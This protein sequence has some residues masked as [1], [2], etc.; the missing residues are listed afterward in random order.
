MGTYLTFHFLYS[1][2][3]W[4]CA[5]NFGSYMFIISRMIDFYMMHLYPMNFYQF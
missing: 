1:D 4:F 2:S 5:F 3:E